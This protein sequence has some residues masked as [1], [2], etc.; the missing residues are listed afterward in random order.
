MVGQTLKIAEVQACL[1]VTFYHQLQYAYLLITSQLSNI[2]VRIFPYPRNVKAPKVCISELILVLFS[3]W[4]NYH[5][6]GS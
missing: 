6:C 5:L 1:F 4:R 2:H 3:H